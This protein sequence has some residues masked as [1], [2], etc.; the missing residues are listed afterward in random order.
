MIEPPASAATRRRTRMPI[1]RRTRV[2]FMGSSMRSARIDFFPISNTERPGAVGAGR[3]P[4][5]PDPAF[6]R[7]S[8]RHV[9][10]R[11]RNERFGELMSRSNVLA[12]CI[13]LAFPLIAAAA[14]APPAPAQSPQDLQA[15]FQRGMNSHNA[16][17]YDESIEIFKALY[18]KL[19]ASQTKTASA[20]NVACGLALKGGHVDEAFAWL[21]KST[22]G[23][24]GAGRGGATQPPDPELARTDTDLDS[25]RKDPRFAKFLESVDANSARASRPATSRPASRPAMNLADET[26][27]ALL[28]APASLDDKTAAPLVVLCHGAGQ[29]K[30]AFL[31]Q[32][33]KDVAD[34]TNVR[35]A[36]VSGGKPHPSGRAQ[37]FPMGGADR[38][39]SESEAIESRLAAAVAQ[40]KQRFAVDANRTFLSGFSQG[41]TVALLAAVRHPEMF[42][43][44]IVVAGS[45]D[46]ATLD[47][48]AAKAAGKTRLVLIAGTNDPTS[49]QS[50]TKACETLTA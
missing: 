32:F 41:G 12:S 2:F 15:D 17:K 18:E 20:Y 19:P 9:F 30:K 10:P 34:A 40:A 46:P 47:P 3:A 4:R 38:Y 5:Y 14:L 49:L 16:G 43:G 26:K 6:W 35:I 48:V 22:A 25:L 39:A 28:Y 31:E 37:W 33:W 13:A 7:S 24:F 42:R 44:A 23:G 29:D 50:L 45:S 11:F 36:S 21:E 8:M 1:A 27:E